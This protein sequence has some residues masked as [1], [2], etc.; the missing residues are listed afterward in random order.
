MLI[1]RKEAFG[2]NELNTL[3]PVS[4]IKLIYEALQDY[5]LLILIASGVLSLILQYT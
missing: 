3:P 1:K 4:F 5:T 2:N